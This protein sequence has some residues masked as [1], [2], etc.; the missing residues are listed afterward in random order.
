MLWTL[1]RQKRHLL[2]L[3]WH[4]ST[5]PALLVTA[6]QVM[7]TPCFMDN[8]KNKQFPANRKGKY[9]SVA[10]LHQA[11]LDFILIY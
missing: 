7:N 6:K 10:A 5:T 8:C 11:D 4:H 9:F 2:P 1:E 3:L